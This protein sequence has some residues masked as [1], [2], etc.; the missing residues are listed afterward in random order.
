VEIVWVITPSQFRALALSQPSATEGAHM[1]HPDFRVGQRGFATLGDPD[2]SWGMIK[3][4]PDQQEIV[5]SAE[6]DV[7]QAAKGAWGKRGSTLILERA[8]ETTA[9]SAIRMAWKNVAM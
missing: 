3:L 2:E 5:V 9:A 8:D 4:R 7:F 1:S 6:P